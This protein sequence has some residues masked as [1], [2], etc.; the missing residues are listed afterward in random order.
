MSLGL[1]FLSGYLLFKFILGWFFSTLA[2]RPLS[3]RLSVTSMLLTSL[4]YLSHLVFRAWHFPGFLPILLATHSLLPLLV[5][6]HITKL[7]NFESLQVQV[8]DLFIFPSILTP[9]LVIPLSLLALNTI[10]ILMIPEVLSPAWT[11][12]QNPRLVYLFAYSTSPLGCLVGISKL[13]FQ[14]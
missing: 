4:K 11:F 8:L 2:R 1:T 6:S 9:L 10:Y 12:P 13:S 7:L 14:N 3:S 5:S